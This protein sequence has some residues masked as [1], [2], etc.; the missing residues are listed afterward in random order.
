MA[1]SQFFIKKRK[2]LLAFLLYLGKS[3][4]RAGVCVPLASRCF[5]L[6][7]AY[8]R[9]TSKL[10]FSFQPP[11]DKKKRMGDKRRE[12]NFFRNVSKFLFYFRGEV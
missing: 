5:F 3:I 6:C 2:K 4:Q 11:R 12:L 7:V 9:V 10:K 1:K 8:L